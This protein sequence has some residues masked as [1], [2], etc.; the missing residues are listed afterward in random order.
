MK[1]NFLDRLEPQD[2]TVHKSISMGL[3]DWSLLE[4]YRFYCA[5]TRGHDISLQRLV[6]EI[7]MD[8]IEANR[9]FAKS[10]D[11][12]LKKIESIREVAQ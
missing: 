6:R 11:Q 8:H 3:N 7:V 4:A 1:K 10:R 9:Q 2:K 5:S 12:W